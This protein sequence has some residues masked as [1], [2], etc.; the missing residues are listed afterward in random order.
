M[1]CPACRT[2]VHKSRGVHPIFLEFVDPKV[3]F[4]D[5]VTEGL[6][7]MDEGTPLESVRRAADKIERGAK[8]TKRN[9]ELTVSGSPAIT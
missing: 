6:G 4:T 9:E 1:P 3:A 2:K 7:K 8:M 5:K